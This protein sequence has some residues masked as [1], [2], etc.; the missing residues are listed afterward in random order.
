MA[1]KTTRHN[2]PQRHLTAYDIYNFA[3]GRLPDNLLY[4]YVL[5]YLRKFEVW[6]DDDDEYTLYDYATG[7]S[8]RFR[9]RENYDNIHDIIQHYDETHD[10]NGYLRPEVV[11]F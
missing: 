6:K 7:L 3:E 11:G 9:G 1:R 10:E 8:I 5:R 2:T 4:P